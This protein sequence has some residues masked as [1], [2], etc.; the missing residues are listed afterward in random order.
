M[1]IFAKLSEAQVVGITLENLK[2]CNKIYIKGKIQAVLDLDEDREVEDH[3]KKGT[4]CEIISPIEFIDIYGDWVHIYLNSK[5]Q[6]VLSIKLE[7]E[8]D[9][10]CTINSKGSSHAEVFNL[11]E[12]E[13]EL[14]K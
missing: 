6:N 7:D 2:I 10:S 11:K 5:V 9:I 12:T 14:I 8:G 1:S 3:S 4:L 13:I